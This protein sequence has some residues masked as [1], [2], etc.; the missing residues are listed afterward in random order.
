[1]PTGETKRERAW[2]SIGEGRGRGK[3]NLRERVIILLENRPEGWP[4]GKKQ[5]KRG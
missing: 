5:K 4:G 1:M 3:S 2:D